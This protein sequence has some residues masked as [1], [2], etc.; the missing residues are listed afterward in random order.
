MIPWLSKCRSEVVV[1]MDRYSSWDVQMGKTVNCW[2]LAGLVRT[3]KTLWLLDAR[4]SV[5]VFNSSFTNIAFSLTIAPV[6]DSVFY[7]SS[8]N[9]TDGSFSLFWGRGHGSIHREYLQFTGLNIFSHHFLIFF[10]K[11]SV[12]VHCNGVRLQKCAH[13]VVPLTQHLCFLW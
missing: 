3:V 11:Q 12:C 4:I 5:A 9:H 13:S 7:V 10:L 8:S 1:G 2:C 6:N